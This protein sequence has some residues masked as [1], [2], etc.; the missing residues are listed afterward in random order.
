M[1]DMSKDETKNKIKDTI[2]LE[3][4]ANYAK[5]RKLGTRQTV[6][7]NLRQL[8]RERV[9]Q[10]Y[11]NI[12]EEDGF[13]C[14]RDDEIFF[15]FANKYEYPQD[16]KKLIDVMCDKDSNIVTQNLKTF[17]D[18]C[19]KKE[20][21]KVDATKLAYNL[22]AGITP[23]H[24]DRVAYLLAYKPLEDHIAY[25]ELRNFGKGKA[26]SINDFINDDEYWSKI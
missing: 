7:Y 11:L 19:E 8:C 5:L 22:M 16:V 3:G 13:V 10:P 1:M 15:T 20:I 6:N 9:I 26:W 24:K 18:L 17:I 4:S 12:G 25:L 21:P 14:P 2:E 23:S